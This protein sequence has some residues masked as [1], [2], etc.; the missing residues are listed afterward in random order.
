[1]RSLGVILDIQAVDHTLQAQLLIQVKWAQT[2][3]GMEQSAEALRILCDYETQANLGMN[4][5]ELCKTVFQAV[6]VPATH[7]PP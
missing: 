6:E 4:E 2:A 3:E 7:L 1:M 5:A